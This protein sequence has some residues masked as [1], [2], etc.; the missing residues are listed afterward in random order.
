MS[1]ERERIQITA[2]EYDDDGVID[3]TMLQEVWFRFRRS[4]L[5]MAGAIGVLIMIAVPYLHL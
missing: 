1:D 5:G 2:E 4:K 3:R